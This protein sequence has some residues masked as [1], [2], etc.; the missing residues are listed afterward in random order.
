MPSNKLI[1]CKEAYLIE[2]IKSLEKNAMKSCI[3]LIPNFISIKHMLRLIDD[4]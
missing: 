3:Y 1:F 4:K 2:K